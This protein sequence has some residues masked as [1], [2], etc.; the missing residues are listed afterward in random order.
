MNETR[1]SLDSRC[2]AEGEL[3]VANDVVDAGYEPDMFGV[4][5]MNAAE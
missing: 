2:K 4:V 5:G 3:D 1:S